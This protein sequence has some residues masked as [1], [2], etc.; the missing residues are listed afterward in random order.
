MMQESRR[1]GEYFTWS[2]I[3][4]TLFSSL[5]AV[6]RFSSAARRS[7]TS[8]EA[9]RSLSA[10]TPAVASAAVTSSFS[11]ESCDE[12]ECDC[13]SPT[14]VWMASMSPLSR[15]TSPRRS[16]SVSYAYGAWD[17]KRSGAKERHKT[18]VGDSVGRSEE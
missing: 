11:A 18:Q 13:T 7:C 12:R 1:A 3:R 10:C 8:I 17:V 15:P 14:S 6:S 4:F 2:Q 9:S 5:A 16:W